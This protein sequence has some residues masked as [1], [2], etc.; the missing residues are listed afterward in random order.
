MSDYLCEYCGQ[1]ASSVASLTASSCIRH[2]AGPNKGR[3]KL[4]EGKTGSTYTCKFCGN[5]SSSISSLT[6][7]PCIRHPTGANKG[8]H[9]PAL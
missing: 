7:S 5:K 8:R 1:K 9:A 4:Y 6:A 2:P 3:H